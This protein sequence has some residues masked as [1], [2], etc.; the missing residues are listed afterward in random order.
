MI[1]TGKESKKKILGK[2][3]YFWTKRDT[4]NGKVLLRLRH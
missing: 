2:S 3:F 1:I 4:S